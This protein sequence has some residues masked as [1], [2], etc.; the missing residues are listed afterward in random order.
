MAEFL[1]SLSSLLF[2]DLISNHLSGLDPVD[3]IQIKA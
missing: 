2:L 1:H 3:S